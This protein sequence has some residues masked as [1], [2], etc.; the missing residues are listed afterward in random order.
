MEKIAHLIDSLNERIGKT[1]SWAALLAVL[2]TFLVVVLRKGFDWGSIAMQ[3]SA[4]Y[5]HALL[6]MAG[7][8]YTFK[9]QGHVRVD[10]FYQKCSTRTRAWI[11]LLGALLLLMPLSIFIVLISADYVLDSWRQLES[12]RETGGLPLFY[13]L[14]T[15]IPVLG[16]LLFLQAI[17]SMIHAWLTLRNLGDKS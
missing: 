9:H 1:I 11:D 14:K 5:F 6:F 16:I 17:S 10:I 2:I 12:S 7:A 4:L 8:A 3:E 15:L 13:L